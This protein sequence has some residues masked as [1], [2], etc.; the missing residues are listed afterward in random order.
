MEI[1]YEKDGYGQL[2]EPKAGGVR[3]GRPRE[4]LVQT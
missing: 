2:S 4:G 3:S 1:F